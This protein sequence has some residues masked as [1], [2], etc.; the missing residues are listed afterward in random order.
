MG[1]DLGGTLYYVR[2]HF[3]LKITFTTQN[4][5]VTR[6][7]KIKITRRAP[8]AFRGERPPHYDI[9]DKLSRTSAAA[10]L[11]VSRVVTSPWPTGPTL[12][13]GDS[14]LLSAPRQHCASR[15]STCAAHHS[16]PGLPG[17]PPPTTLDEALL[18]GE[19][20]HLT[21]HRLLDLE[22]QRNLLIVEPR[23]LVVLSQAV[24]EGVVVEVLVGSLSEVRVRVSAACSRRGSSVRE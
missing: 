18:S 4:S 20:V 10:R 19:V 5:Q 8:D 9:R 14:A 6:H 13:P 1:G 3:L 11:R 21:L 12:S 15:I 16:T 22:D 17:W 23:D 2:V 7:I 24:G